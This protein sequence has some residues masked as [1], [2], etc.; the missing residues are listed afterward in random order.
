MY[1]L[2][3]STSITRL[4]DGAS[5][6][7]DEQNTD[8]AAYLQ[9]LSEG[10]TPTPADPVPAPTYQELRA[11]A[12]PPFSDYLDGIVKGSA[13]QVQEYVDACLAVKERFP[14]PANGD[15]A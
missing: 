9:W 10:N 8:Y 12:Y 7:A 15:I 14:K 13:E 11:A 4:S 3:Q 1:K 6:P 5:I 2:N